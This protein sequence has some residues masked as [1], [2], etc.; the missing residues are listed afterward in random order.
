MVN[1]FNTKE[2]FRTDYAAFSSYDNIRKIANVID[3]QKNASRKIL[4]FVMNNNINTFTK[5]SN[6]SSRIQDATSYL[7]GSL[8]GTVVNNAQQ[9]VGSNNVPMLLGDGTFG[10]RFINEPAASRYIFA[11]LNPKYSEFFNDEDYSILDHQIFE[12]DK[13]EPKYYVPILP[14][15]LV[16]GANGVSVGFSQKILPRSVKS[17]IKQLNNLLTGEKLERIPP[18]F[19][20]FTGSI[21]GGSTSNQWIINGKF[22]RQTKTQLVIT[23]LPIGYDLKGYIDVLESLVDNGK[24]RAYADESENDKFRFVIGVTREVGSLS[25]DKLMSLLKLSKP[26]TENFTAIDIHNRVIQFANELDIIRYWLNVRLEYNEKRK[27]NTLKSLLKKIIDNSIRARFIKAV[28]DRDIIL[29]NRSKQDIL[30][31]LKKFD[32]ELYEYDTNGGDLLKM[33]LYSITSEKIIE[34]SNKIDELRTEYDIVASKSPEDLL[35]S[36]LARIS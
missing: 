28:I 25:D 10:T 4:H 33:P 34:L 21:E 36:D 29:E 1:T 35:K 19:E 22:E 15:I 7:H 20:G 11:K 17:I 16:N 23:E 32:N 6:L 13:I 8:E 2:F 18:Y 3:G 30:D 27:L 5:V 24:I 9:F 14:L 26:I 31:Q 12:G